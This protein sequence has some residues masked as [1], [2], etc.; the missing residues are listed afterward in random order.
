MT[1]SL[2]MN[3]KDIVA[4]DKPIVSPEFRLHPYQRQ[5]Y[6]D[7]LARLDM[8]ERRVVAHLPTGAGKTRIATHV[9]AHML[10]SRDDPDALVVWLAASEELCDQAAESL[11]MAWSHL[12]Q[13]E[14]AVYRYWGN[15]QVDF[16][17]IEGG[18]IVTGLAKLYSSSQ[19]NKNLLPRMA[20]STGGIVFDEAHQA[21]AP[22]YAYVVNQ[23]CSNSPQ[24]LGLT[25]TPGRTAN[26]TDDD[27]KL[28][29]MFERS[30]VGIDPKGHVSPVTYL[31][32]NRYLANPTFRRIEID[33]E[34]GEDYG[35]RQNDY[36]SKIL[37]D[38]GID[39]GRNERIVRITKDAL[40]R[41]KRVLVFCPSVDSAL[42]C[43]DALTQDDIKASAVTAQTATF[44]RRQIMGLIYLTSHAPLS[45]PI[46]RRVVGVVSV[47]L[48][49]AVRAW[50][51]AGVAR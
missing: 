5:V 43:T 1:V 46:P 38:L 9:A 28:A 25:A 42:I 17:E 11:E 36:D 12:G 47:A 30:K 26:F 3:A 39:Q 16:D 23:L 27:H 4:S 20:Q 48:R 29:D 32:N 49:P 7:I 18:F 51:S 40:F 41:H 15:R 35:D 10:N 21:I 33:S 45:A 50:C 6:R 13:R 2:R 37:E 31:I 14:A 19:T 34:I 24:L 22:T 8:P 44:E